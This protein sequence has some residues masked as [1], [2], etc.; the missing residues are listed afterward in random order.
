MTDGESNDGS[1]YDVQKY[2]H[3]NKETTPIYSI[4]FGYSDERQ[5]RQ[6]AELSNAKVF[7]GKSGLKEAFAE[8][9]SYN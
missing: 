1:F 8:V 9:R 3:M 7:D 5:L 2:Y 6:L 4:T